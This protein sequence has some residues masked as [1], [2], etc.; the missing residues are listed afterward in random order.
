MKK[1]ITIIAILTLGV[2]SAQERVK[3]AAPKLNVL[4]PVYLSNYTTYNIL[5]VDSILSPKT[6]RTF[7]F[8]KGQKYHVYV[9]GVDSLVVGDRVCLKM[10]RY[11]RVR[12]PSKKK[13]VEFIVSEKDFK[14][15][16]FN[17]DFNYPEEYNDKY[18]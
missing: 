8:A 2:S 5:E 1:L 6:A 15:F 17:L 18:Y 11:A 3:V 9:K 13:D 16:L 14:R 12:K 4:D 7:V 10:G